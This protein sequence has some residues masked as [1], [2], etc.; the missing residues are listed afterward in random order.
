MLEKRDFPVALPEFDIVANYERVSVFFRR[1][2]VLSLEIAF[3]DAAIGLDDIGAVVLWHL[4]PQSSAA[5]ITSDGPWR[6]SNSTGEYEA[7]HQETD[8]S[9]W[10]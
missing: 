1:I 8:P 6:C 2:I 4:V 5:H 9:V 3:R 7:Y 10:F